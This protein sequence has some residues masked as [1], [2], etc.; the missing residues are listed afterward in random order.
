MGYKLKVTLMSI[1]AII[2]LSGVAIEI[3]YLFIK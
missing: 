2:L 3:Y 1:A